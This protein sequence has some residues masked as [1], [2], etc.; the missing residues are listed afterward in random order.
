VNDRYNSIFSRALATKSNG[1]II[2]CL[3]KPTNL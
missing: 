1:L 3:G 2:K